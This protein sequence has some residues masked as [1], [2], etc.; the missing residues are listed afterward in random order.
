MKVHHSI[1]INLA[2][3]GDSCWRKVVDEAFHTSAYV[4]TVCNSLLLCVWWLMW[5]WFWFAVSYGHQSIMELCSLAAIWW[6]KIKCLK[7]VIL[8]SSY[9]LMHRSFSQFINS[10]RTKTRLFG[11]AQITRCGLLF[12]I[13][14][15][16]SKLWI[17]IS[18]L[19][20]RYLRRRAFLLRPWR[21]HHVLSAN[22]SKSAQQRLVTRLQWLL[23]LQ[24]R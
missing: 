3:F 5:L 21:I 8:K 1:E 2:I 22:P 17:S 9:C 12:D 11:C 18:F 13:T 16:R 14:S 15:D 4:K 20:R 6:I 24:L 10:N 23:V 7:P 19:R